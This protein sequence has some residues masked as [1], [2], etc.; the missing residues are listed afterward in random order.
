MATSSKCSQELRIL[1]LDYPRTC[2]ECGLD[3]CLNAD[4]LALSSS[5]GKDLT[6]VEAATCMSKGVTLEVFIGFQRDDFP[7]HTVSDNT[8][9]LGKRYRVRRISTNVPSH[10][11]FAHHGDNS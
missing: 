5:Q 3:R 10:P 4:I 2:Q 9:I 1:G 7:W 6:F 11:Y 8:L